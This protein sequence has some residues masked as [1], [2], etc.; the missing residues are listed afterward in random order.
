MPRPARIQSAGYLHHVV[1]KGNDSQSLFAGQIDYEAYQ[2]L[3]NEARQKYPV[4]LY[5]YV[6]M[7]NHVHLLVEPDEDGALSKF[8][9]YVTKGYAKY[10]N[11]VNGRM[12]HVFQ[13]RFKS[14][15][16]QSDKYFFACSR[17]IDLNP[18]KAKIV[19]DPS[20]YKWSAFKSLAHGQPCEVSVDQHPL[21]SNLGKSE[22][23]RQLVYRAFVFN[24]TIEDLDLFDRRAGVLG[25][26]E[27][28]QRLKV[29]HE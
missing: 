14:F 28:K 1:S 8:M 11:K 25:D 13:G 16:V 26:K 18:V 7:S 24:Q 12:G 29:A 2:I 17:Y 20:E 4:K 22:E 19:T 15:T 9:E 23:E 5:N 6:L 10:F 27:F 3:I 21:Y